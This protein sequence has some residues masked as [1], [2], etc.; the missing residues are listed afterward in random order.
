MEMEL[1]NPQQAEWVDSKVPEVLLDD[2]VSTVEFLP[3][4]LPY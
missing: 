1:D 2:R 4:L 3:S